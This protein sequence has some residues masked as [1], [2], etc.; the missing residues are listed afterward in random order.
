MEACRLCSEISAVI[1]KAWNEALFE[2]ANF[3]A[4]PSLGSLVE[5]WLLLVPKVHRIC[6]GALGD[7][8]HEMLQIKAAVASVLEQQY[9]SVCV[10]EH[11]P[12]AEKRHVGC[13]VDHAH[14]HFAPLEFDLA[15]AALP[16]MPNQTTWRDAGP[17]DCRSAYKLGKDYLYIEQ[18]LGVGRIAIADAFGSQILRRTIAKEIGKPD[19]FNWREYPQIANVDATRRDLEKW[20]LCQSKTEAIA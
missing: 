15:T 20:S 6:M 17:E 8:L 12:S 16:F 13:G 3:V 11:G 7:D 14:L 5:G 1:P 18:P 19:E 10:F 2:S 9:G 4:I